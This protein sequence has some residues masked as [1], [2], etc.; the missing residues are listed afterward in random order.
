MLIIIVIVMLVCEMKKII[1]LMLVA[2]ALFL[3]AACGGVDNAD[4]TNTAEGL[5]DGEN[6]GVLRDSGSK[7][8]T[9]IIGV[10]GSV[11]ARASFT[12]GTPPYK[13]KYSCFKGDSPTDTEDFTD[14]T[15]QIISFSSSGSYTVRITA[16]DAA[17]EQAYKDI[18]ITAKNRIVNYGIPYT[19]EK[20]CSDID[21]LALTYPDIIKAY[22]I[23]YS[24]QH[25]DIKTVAVGRGSKKALVV[26]GIHSR[27][28][29][30]VS[31]VMRCVEEYARAYCENKKYGDYNINSILD[32]YT[33]YFVPMSN[34]DGTNI[35]VTRK[36]SANVSIKGFDPDA[37]KANANGV[38]LNRN[39][40]F[41]W[42]EQ[43]S[44]IAS[45]V[46]DTDYPGASSASESETRAIIEL[47]DDNDF[48]WLLDMHILGNGIYWRDS[49]NGEIK[50]DSRL[51]KK[52][53]EKCSYRIFE[54]TTDPD[55]Y[56]GGLENW[57]RYEYKRPAFC[58]E[59]IPFEQ[60][61]KW[62][63]YVGYNYSFDEAVDWEKT[64]YTFL[65]ALS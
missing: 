13:Y 11:T 23:G 38:N 34:P 43:Y 33:I 54:E 14:N 59:L 25:R 62:D 56:S 46:G 44:K 65:A 36:N 8:N 55:L 63:S 26:G 61:Q 41:N 2:A 37:F 53:T 7:L 39:F 28:H 64:K 19:Y 40:P 18:K 17:G 27:E 31:F 1:T 12:G 45:T 15:K 3:L 58:I 52:I 35:S 60:G 22:S 20:L 4:K 47:C 16:Q 51:L 48:E 5:S 50:G 9:T 42:E 21:C 32:E 6:D 57:F 30:T 49:K 10:N 29:I 24:E